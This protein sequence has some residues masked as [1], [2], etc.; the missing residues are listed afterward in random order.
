MCLLGILILYKNWCWNWFCKTLKACLQDPKTKIALRRSSSSLTWYLFSILLTQPC[1]TRNCREM[2]QGR[3][4]DAAISTI[5]KRMWLGRG[6]P[7]MKTPPSWF[8]R[9]CPETHKQNWRK[10]KIK[11]KIDKNQTNK[12]KVLLMRCLFSTVCFNNCN[13]FVNYTQKWCGSV[14]IAK[15]ETTR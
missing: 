15:K 4:P 6:R 14:S 10:R 3:T 11:L 9:P 13:S 1:D 5:F 12:T 8:T 7:F 2:T